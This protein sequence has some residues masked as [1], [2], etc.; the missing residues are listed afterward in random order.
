MA[1]LALDWVNENDDSDS[2]EN[3][4]HQF[5]LVFLVELRYV[6]DNSSLEQII[7]KQHGL[8]GKKIA[9]SQIRSI[10]EGEYGNKVLL[11]LDGYDEYSKGTNDDID[12]AIKDTIGDCFLILTSR[13][14]DYIS[15][16][17]LDKMD[18]K[19]ELRGFTEKSM[20][21]CAT[22][23][24]ESKHLADK[25]IKEAKQLRIDELL[26]IPIILLMVCVLFFKEHTLPRSQ[27]AIIGKIL[28]LCIDRSGLKHFGKRSKDIP[29]LEDKLFCLG[30][31]AW[32]TLKRSTRQLLLPKVGE[33]FCILILFYK[34]ITK[35]S[36]DFK[37]LEMKKYISQECI[38]VRCVPAER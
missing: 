19:I 5:D 16:E 23:Y 6:N 32:K 29:W 31:L 38:P 12:A 4:L 26:Q 2:T 24:L 3:K 27:T 20:E 36:F 11:L 10:L 25:L 17:T 35:K 15:K 37:K 28:E 9:E 14:G 22:K 33:R 34:L 30:E 1:M 18:G 8:K 13:D 7:I 21:E